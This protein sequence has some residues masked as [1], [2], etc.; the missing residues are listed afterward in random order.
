MPSQSSG[1]AH[2]RRRAT[3]HRLSRFFM[4][5]PII[6]HSEELDDII[7]AQ[8]HW[9]VR[10]GTGLFL[11]LL[12]ALLLLS[13]LVKYPTVV[14]CRLA[15]NAVNAPK[16]VLARATSHLTAVLVRDQAPV[17][18]GQMLALLENPA[19][20]AQVLRLGTHLDSLARTGALVSRTQ[21]PRRPTYFPAKLGELQ[22]KYQVFAQAYAQLYNLRAG[23]FFAKK[24]RL[25]RAELATLRLGQQNLA[26]QNGLYERDWQ[27]AHQEMLVQQK[28]AGK[29]IIAA[30]D[31]RREQSRE[32][33]K[34]FP[35]RQGETIRL[36]NLT[37]QRAKEEEL[38]DLAKIE[39]EQ[40]DIYVQSLNTLRSAVDEWKARYV[41]VAP[42]TGRVNFSGVLEASQLVRVDQEV[43]FIS[44]PSVSYYGE[45]QVPQQNLGKVKVGQ[46]V[47][48]K[49]DGYPFNEFGVVEGRVVYLSEI[50]TARNGFFAKVSLPH[51]LLTTYGKKVVFR[52]HISAQADILT[53][54][55][56]L[57][58]RILYQIRL[59]LN[60]LK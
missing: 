52:N 47:L 25:L 43:F 15:L 37:R 9:F 27:L 38:L 11:L 6:L 30:S 50:P 34:Q 21:H 55:T 53:E 26:Q 13:W 2:A 20:N 40:A 41:L 60:S 33:A 48:I 14:R 32:L 44:R 35:M 3:I 19:D 56:R 22:V 8:P 18:K 49:L 36:D 5:A 4:A 28:L 31:F 24:E 42:E 17:R 46:A 29:G 1:S 54:D 7:T 57:L 39:Q 16:P 12:A 59:S 23:G 45:M 58:E 10:L 51:G